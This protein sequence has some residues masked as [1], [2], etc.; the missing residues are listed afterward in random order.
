MGESGLKIKSGHFWTLDPTAPGSDQIGLRSRYST[1]QQERWGNHGGGAC[2]SSG[3]KAVESRWEASRAK[4]SLET[5]K[6]TD[7]LV[8]PSSGREPQPRFVPL[9]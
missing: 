1:I 4:D 7:K 8:I 9:D 3:S 5:T 2:G 6:T